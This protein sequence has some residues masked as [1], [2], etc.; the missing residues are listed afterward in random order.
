[1]GLTTDA[2]KSQDSNG[3]EDHYYKMA[4]GFRLKGLPRGLKS[5]LKFWRSWI[6]LGV[7][8]MALPLLFQDANHHEAFKC[9]YVMLIM[10]TF[11]VTEALPLAITSLIPVAILPLFGIM[12]TDAVGREYLKETN[13]MFI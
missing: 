4:D 11:W 8:L 13:M 12:S 3:G 6:I 2:R 1:M 9:A 5:L 10:A 7:P